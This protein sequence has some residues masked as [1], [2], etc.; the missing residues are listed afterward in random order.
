MSESS[1]RRA[2]SKFL[3]RD[4]AASFLLYVCRHRDSP[5]RD[6]HYTPVLTDLLAA[7][8]RDP[9]R[10]ALYLLSSV[11][12]KTLRALQRACSAAGSIGDSGERS[13]A[14]GAN[15]EGAEQAADDELLFFVGKAGTPQAASVWAADTEADAATSDDD[16]VQGAR[17]RSLSPGIAEESGE[18]ED[19]DEST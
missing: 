4:T 1:W 19:S 16:R 17:L 6:R 15:E 5:T 18:D 12:E 7:V 2:E 13:G 8:K 10:L 9:S 3:K 14:M 11:P